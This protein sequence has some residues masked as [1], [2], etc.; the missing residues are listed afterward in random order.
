MHCVFLKQS[1]CHCQAKREGKRDHTDR[2]K[3]R[4]MTEKEAREN[5]SR[6]Y[7]LFRSRETIP[8]S[9][10]ARLWIHIR[11]LAM[12]ILLVIVTVMKVLLMFRWH[13][14]VRS[15]QEADGNANPLQDVL[16]FWSP[17][18]LRTSKLIEENFSSYLH[19]VLNYFDNSSES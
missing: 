2:S 1:H 17:N 7:L 5:R 9:L 4:Y 14:S 8:R 11:F 18:A 3:C 6:F 13:I 16:V 12:Q 15:F 19:Y 10:Y